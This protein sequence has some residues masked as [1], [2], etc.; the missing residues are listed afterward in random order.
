MDGERFGEFD[1]CRASV[2]MVLVEMGGL[3]AL[4]I[5]KESLAPILIGGGLGGDKPAI[6]QGR[7]DCWVQFEEVE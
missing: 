1:Y 5:L 2:N 3:G 6:G 7:W 4:L